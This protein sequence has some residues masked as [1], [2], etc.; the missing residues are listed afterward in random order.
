MTPRAAASH[1]GYDGF[2]TGFRRAGIG[3]CIAMGVRE[4]PGL[5]DRHAC[6]F[7]DQA[8]ALFEFRAQP[9]EMSSGTLPYRFSPAILFRQACRKGVEIRDQFRIDIVVDQASAGV[10]RI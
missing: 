1:R 10:V 8:N 2:T 9:D 4:N 5:I 3:A 7:G 6:R